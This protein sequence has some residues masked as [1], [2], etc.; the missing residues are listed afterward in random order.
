MARELLYATSMWVYVLRVE[1]RALL[2]R[3]FDHLMDHP[4]V[5]SCAIEPEVSR[6]RF[7]AETRTGDALVERIYLEGGLSWCTRHAFGQGGGD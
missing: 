3:A 6:L 5:A 1:E 7:I 4:E 2:A